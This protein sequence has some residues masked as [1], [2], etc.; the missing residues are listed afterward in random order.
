MKWTHVPLGPNCTKI[1]SGVT[2][3]G[4]DA[5]YI[6]E[7][8]ALIRSQ[9]VYNGGFS[10]DGLAFIDE[11]QAEQMSG[12]EIHPNDVLLNITGDSVARCCLV[13]ENIL[14]ARVNQHVAII[15]PDSQTINPKFLMYYLVTPYMQSSMLSISGSGGT[16]KAL[17]KTM[18]EKFSVPRP[19][20]KIQQKI[21][22]KLAPYDELI[23][24]NSRRIKLLEESARLLYRE[25]FVHF[26]FPG[27]EH[28]KISNRLPCN[29]ENLHLSRLVSPQYGF[30]ET[31]TREPIGP[32]FL[33][34]TD[35]NKTSYI[36]WDSVPFCSEKKLDYEKYAL[37]IGDI[38]VV[39]MAD[40]GKIA[41][42]EKELK[43]VFASYLVRLN[44]RPNVNIE[45]QYLFHTL[46]DDPY[47]SFISGASDKSTRKSANA[48]L[49]T[50]FQITVPP[51][52]LQKL[53]VEHVGPLRRQL[54]ILLDQNAIL[55]KS[56]DILL[57]KLM[58]GFI[59][60]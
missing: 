23:E 37:K 27:H 8:V 52:S 16:R 28:V 43:A 13:P 19:N 31:A 14:P 22:D 45:P 30:T 56:R 39:R 11:E 32:R 33:R 53:F 55:K 10:N 7:G 57:P 34:G 24:N 38:L 59:Q 25:W 4:G 40:P 42:V 1:G 46:S 29:W 35:I 44:I 54:N 2:P 3:R 18:I 5:V 15:R 41:I 48:Q 49:L 6:D 50:D 47:Q 36:N 21:V 17:T 58:S 26:R 9:N 12:V 60:V 51:K 20:I